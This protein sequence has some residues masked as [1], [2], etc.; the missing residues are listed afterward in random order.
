MRTL[1]Q[2]VVA[3]MEILECLGGP[4]ILPSLS[5]IVVKSQNQVPLYQTSKGKRLPGAPTRP[6][7]RNPQRQAVRP[8]KAASNRD[9]AIDVLKVCGEHDRT[10]RMLEYLTAADDVASEVWNRIPTHK[11]CPG[12]LARAQEIRGPRR[13][14]YCRACGAFAVPLNFQGMVSADLIRTRKAMIK[15]GWACA[16]ET[17]E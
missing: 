14:A 7:M 13:K 8:D 3:A 2:H 5:S 12:C 9:Y 11:V 4:T 15:G 16:K 6:W 10:G 17:G 1:R